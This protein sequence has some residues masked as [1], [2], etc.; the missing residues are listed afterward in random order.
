MSEELRKGI[1]KAISVEPIEL[2]KKE[3]EE[4][5]RYFEA[6]LKREGVL[7][8]DQSIEDVERIC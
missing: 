6:K 1:P 8:E 2:T 4:L 7:R 3:S 5:D